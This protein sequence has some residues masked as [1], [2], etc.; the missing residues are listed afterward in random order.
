MALRTDSSSLRGNPENDDDLLIFGAAKPGA[1][2]GVSPYS[3]GWST[4]SFS[5]GTT[6]L[7]FSKTFYHPSSTTFLVKFSYKPL[8]SD[9]IPSFSRGSA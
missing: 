1:L 9:P 2:A 3:R 5:F 6:I 7:S 4:T 8:I